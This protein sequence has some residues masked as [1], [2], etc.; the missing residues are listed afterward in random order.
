MKIC[1][2][3]T[4]D[5]W[6][7]TKVACAN[8]PVTRRLARVAQ[9]AFTMVE[10]AISLAV[11]G[12]ALVAILGVLPI[13]MRSQRDNRERTLI[14]Q[15]ATVFMETI[16]NGAARAED[17]T[18]YVYAITNSW[19]HFTPGSRG[20]NNKG[21]NSYTYNSAFIST[22]YPGQ[23]APLTNGSIIIGLLSTPEYTDDNGEPIADLFE[24]GYSNHIVA[25]VHALSGP[26]VEKPPQNNPILFNSVLNYRLICENLPPATDTNALSAFSTNLTANLHDLRLTFLWPQLPNGSLAPMPT[27]QTFRTLVAG[28][29]DLK[30]NLITAPN[31]NLYFFQPQSF[32]TNAP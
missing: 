16:R 22:P 6:R 5:G 3:V 8:N 19:V 7:V 14:N 25:Y 26:A 18:N 29:L 27:R 11:I 32:A 1:C 30:T 13:G 17:L 2:R 28:R 21:V 24:G 31:V 23:A 4:S 9:H 10:I 12:I 15:D 20:K